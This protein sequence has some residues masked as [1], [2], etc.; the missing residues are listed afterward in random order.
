MFDNADRVETDSHA[1]S[2]ALASIAAGKLGRLFSF[3][4]AH[5]GHHNLY[6][7][8]LPAGTYLIID[9]LAD[10]SS[11]VAATY[12]IRGNWITD[13]QQATKNALRLTAQVHE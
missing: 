5:D 2:I 6:S 9:A 7:V 12:L 4:Q 11:H 8:E 10:D 13:I 1:G 3:Y